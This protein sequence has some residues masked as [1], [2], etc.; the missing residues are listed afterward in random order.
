M[1]AFEVIQIE[2]AFLPCVTDT[3]VINTNRDYTDEYCNFHTDEHLNTYGNDN[4]QPNSFT[5]ANVCSGF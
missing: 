3:R 2:I 4:S 1:I 5:N